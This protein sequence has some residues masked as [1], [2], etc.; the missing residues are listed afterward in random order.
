MSQ[1]KSA[2]IDPFP[3]KTGLLDDVRRVADEL[4]RPPNSLEYNEMGDRRHSSFYTYWDSW[5]DAVEAAGFDP[6]DMKDG[7][8]EHEYYPRISDEELLDELRIGYRALGYPPT[9]RDMDAFGE[10]GHAT[11]E[12]RFGGWV[13]ALEEAGIP[14]P[15]SRKAISE[16]YEG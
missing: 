15:E 7:R 3:G 2:E 1:D 6:D 9:S 16:G 14:V 11:Y 4:G 12:R 13:A 10:Y 8:G 5:S